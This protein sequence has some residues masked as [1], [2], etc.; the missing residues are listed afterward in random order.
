MSVVNMEIDKKRELASD[1]ATPAEILKELAKDENVMSC[2]AGNPSTPIET[3]EELMNNKKV[4]LGMILASNP[5]IT[6]ELLVQ[7][8]FDEERET[9]DEAKYYLA[10][11]PSISVEIVERLWE[12]GSIDA[13][14]GLADNP[15]T[16]V[17]FLKRLAKDEDEYV[18]N[19]LAR[20]PSTPVETLEELSN[21]EDEETRDEANMQLAMRS[22]MDFENVDLDDLSYL[23]QNLETRSKEREAQLKILNERYN[24]K[25]I[26]IDEIKM[27]IGK[28]NQLDQQIAE[29]RQTLRGDTS[30]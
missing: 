30:I 17:E 13:R 21:D 28:N 6:V 27:L 26:L 11:H 2:V 18:R 7:M 29:V 24:R 9:A 25:K 19:N 3:L 12:D 8:A 20:N 23:K 10:K 5:A 22:K 14:Q 16:P 4:D 15:S 1:P